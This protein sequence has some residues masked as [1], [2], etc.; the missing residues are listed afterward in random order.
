MEGRR[1]CLADHDARAVHDLERFEPPHGPG[2]DEVAVEEVQER[3]LHMTGEQH[4]LGLQSP[5]RGAHLVAGRR[6]AG[7]ALDGLA[8]DD[9]AAERFERATERDRQHAGASLGA[10]RAGAVHHREVAENEGAA[11]D[12]GVG[13]VLGGEPQQGGFELLALERL[14]HEVVR[15]HEQT[16]DR[17]LTLER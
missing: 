13:S 5:L 2:I 16:A 17:V 9:R 14:L 4:A 11:R 1:S 7:D 3:G 15:V 8:G 10:V 12:V 6:S